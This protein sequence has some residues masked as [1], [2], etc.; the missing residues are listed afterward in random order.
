M[1]FRGKIKRGEIYIAN[2]NPALGSEQGY[3]R[4]VLIISNDLSHRNSRN[5]VVIAVPITASVS[6]KKK[7]MP[8]YIHIVPTESNGQ[9]KEALIDCGQIR[10]LD[11]DERLSKRTGMVD[12]KTMKKVDAAL[13]MALQLST[14]PK[15]DTVLFP[16]KNHCVACKHILVEV[17]RECHEVISTDFKYCPHCSTERGGEG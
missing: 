2:L 5:P 17:C 16:N 11:I 7:A 1:S 3:E 13:D 15:C 10:V 8:K 12:S 9:T 4:R 14:C 6:D